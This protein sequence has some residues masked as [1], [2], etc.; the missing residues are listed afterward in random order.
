MYGR[1]GL[2]HPLNPLIQL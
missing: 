1:P 2:M